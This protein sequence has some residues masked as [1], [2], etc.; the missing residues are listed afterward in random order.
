MVSLGRVPEAHLGVEALAVAAPASTS[1]S[2]FH[3]GPA[4]ESKICNLTL[5]GSSV[6]IPSGDSS[7]CEF[8]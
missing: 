7:L 3:P 1:P 5:T 4:P 8:P 6:R 2:D